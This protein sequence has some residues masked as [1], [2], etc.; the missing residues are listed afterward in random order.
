MA[1]TQCALSFL[2]QSIMFLSMDQPSG[3]RHILKVHC[4]VLGP[5]FLCLNKDK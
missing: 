2:I 3:W 4:V 1:E 5:T